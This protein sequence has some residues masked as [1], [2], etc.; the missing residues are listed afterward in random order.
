MRPFGVLMISIFLLL[1]ALVCISGSLMMLLFEEEARNLIQEEFKHIADIYGISEDVFDEVYDTM[2]ISVFLIGLVYFIN[3]AGI[4][5]LKNWARLL[6]I[7]LFSFQ[8]L[9]SLLLIYYDPF[10]AIYIAISIAVIWYL[11]RADIAE[12]FKGKKMS[13]EERV[14]GQKP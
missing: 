12:T 6:A 7:I 2:A 9:Y 8:M 10:A 14:L 4:F 1:M 13:I 5:M 3:S 11:L